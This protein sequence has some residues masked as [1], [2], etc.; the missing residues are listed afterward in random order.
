MIVFVQDSIRNRDV[1]NNEL[2]SD[3][4]D[5][6]EIAVAMLRLIDWIDRRSGAI[7]VYV[8][9]SHMHLVFMEGDSTNTAALATVAWHTAKASYVLEFPYLSEDP[10]WQGAT[11][12]A[13]EAFV[14][15]VLNLLVKHRA[16]PEVADSEQSTFVDAEAMNDQYW[17]LSERSPPPVGVLCKAMLTLMSR[18]NAT[19]V[20]S[21]LRFAFIPE[22]AWIDSP[23]DLGLYITNKFSKKPSVFV[24][25]LSTNMYSVSI[26]ADVKSLWENARV[27]ISGVSCNDALVVII[28]WLKCLTQLP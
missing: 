8:C 12:V 2:R 14:E 19:I 3:S 27:Q 5:R 20:L 7:P 24:A 6:I 1:L 18:L 9:L 11:I 21:D 10:A 25:P 26:P 22:S 4:R 15:R 16:V 17:K 28:N 23:N 13:E